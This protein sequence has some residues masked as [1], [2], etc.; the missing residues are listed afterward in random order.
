MMYLSND[1]F[2]RNPNRRTP[3]RILG[4][5]DAIQRRMDRFGTERREASDPRL[6]QQVP[7]RNPINIDSTTPAPGPMIPPRF[8]T[9][10]LK[11]EMQNRA[12]QPS[13][14]ERIKAQ[15][16]DP[17]LVSGKE[18]NRGR[19]F[20]SFDADYENSLNQLQSQWGDLSQR[21]RQG[22]L[23]IDEAFDMQTRGLDR[24]RDRS[25]EDLQD[26][27][28]SQGIL[29]SGI[30]VAEQDNIGAQFTGAVEQATLQRRTALQQLIEQILGSQR[31]I[32]SERENII[33]ERSAREEQKAREEAAAAAQAAANAALQQ[34]I[35]DAIAAAQQANTPQPNPNGEIPTPPVT[36]QPPPP[37]TVP[38]LPP[39]IP[40]QPE[41]VQAGTPIDNGNFPIPGPFKRPGRENQEPVAPQP[42]PVVSDAARPSPSPTGGT[43][44]FNG[45]FKRIGGRRR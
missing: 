10:N 32:E 14:L 17:D 18:F 24:Q 3:A 31:N 9:D 26:R 13:W 39:I 2:K 43:N 45:P 40:S 41:P 36:E 15:N 38:Q 27:L 29:R 28:A 25:V 30:N 20:G 8:E 1:E 16:P 44:V 22:R 21:E 11:T 35:L 7:E 12:K 4:Q 37:S 34:Q 23:G 6:S 5:D 42:N 33:R 19:G